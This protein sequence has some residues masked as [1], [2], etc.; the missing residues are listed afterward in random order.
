MSNDENS[1][2]T[3]SGTEEASGHIIVGEDL[4]VSLSKENRIAAY[5]REDK[6]NDVK[7]GTYVQVP[8]PADDDDED[9]ND[10]LIAMVDSL[11][12]VNRMEI[13]EY[14]GNKASQMSPDS[15]G[16]E[17]RY[18]LIAELKPISVVKKNDEGEAHETKSTATPPKP[19]TSMYRAENEEF[20]RVGLNIPEEGVIVGHTAVN[21][22]KVPPK[23]PLTYKLDNPGHNK[24]RDSAIWR[25]CLVSGSTGKGKTHF[26]K[27]LISQ[28]TTGPKFSIE[29]EDGRMVNRKPCVVVIDPENEYSQMAEDPDN[30]D[31]LDYLQKQGVEVGGINESNDTDFNL[32][33]FVPDAD[34][35]DSVTAPKSEKKKFHIPFEL[36]RSHPKLAMSFEANR[37]TFEAMRSMLDSFFESNPN[38]TYAEFH[39]RIQSEDDRPFEENRF[40]NRHNIAE[41]VWDAALSRF[42]SHAFHSVFDAGGDAVTDILDDLVQPGQV[43]VIPTGHL[44]PGRQ[45]LV[46]MSLLS[47]MVEHK[48]GSTESAI[49]H[50]PLILGLDEAHNYLSEGYTMRQRHIVDR[51]RD[52]AKQGRKYKLGLFMITQNPEDVDEEIRKQTNSKIY[53]GLERETLERLGL[54]PEKKS[55]I[56]SFGKGQMLVKAPDVEAVEVLG[57]KDCVTKHG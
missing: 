30:I 9:N 33:T 34:G 46:V 8:F 13:N 45:K 26:T 49:T 55:K 12:Y 52:A 14:D 23:N 10:E 54:E 5:I 1:L 24:E 2:S 56:V 57:F 19:F 4:T 27:N 21:G 25:H 28:F 20:L 35:A 43:S 48:I 17:R 38:G 3:K 41:S 37:P 15:E 22:E 31:E 29:G 47:M 32:K 18:D 53:L 6:R 40:A 7:T 11:T 50:T 51:F 39:N 16:N 44:S 42:N 36:A